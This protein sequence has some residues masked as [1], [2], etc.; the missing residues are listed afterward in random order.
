MPS[1]DDTQALSD[2][3]FELLF[4]AERACLEDSVA[5]RHALKHACANAR[6]VLVR[7]PRE[8]T[9]TA[10]LRPP[11]TRIT[12]EVWD[13]TYNVARLIMSESEARAHVAEIYGPQPPESEP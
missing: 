7:G 4:A 10:V 3:F 13:A 6:A 11:S 1:D 12:R 2:A 5:A 9:S 8:W